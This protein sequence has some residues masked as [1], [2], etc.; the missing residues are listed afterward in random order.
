MEKDNRKCRC[1]YFIDGMLRAL[2]FLVVVI[3]FISIFFVVF[4]EPLLDFYDKHIIVCN[5]TKIPSDTKVIADLVNKNKIVP[6]S[7]IISE[8]SSFYT[9][10]ITILSIFIGLSG[11]LGYI[12]IRSLGKE[13]FEKNKQ[14]I[15]KEVNNHFEIYT[16]SV[17]FS[18]KVGARVDE[19][20]E[21]TQVEDIN[22]KIERL[23]NQ[24]ERIQ[25]S[26]TYEDDVISIPEE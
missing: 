13:E 3:F 7:D 2:G 20:L 12:H 16:Q 22:R 21:G 15:E 24:L 14:F 6:L 25:N 19:A 23:E 8:L 1:S 26:K 18:N 10:I 4:K 5:D 17:K 11:L 9:V